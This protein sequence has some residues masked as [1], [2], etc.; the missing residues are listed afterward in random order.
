MNISDF[1]K[2][3]PYGALVENVGHVHS[4]FLKDIARVGYPQYQ[5]MLSLF[6]ATPERYFKELQKTE[7]DVN[8]TSEQIK[9]LQMF[10]IYT[11]TKEGRTLLQAA[12]S[13]F[14]YGDFSWDE[15]GKRFLINKQEQDGKLYVDGFVN[16]NNYSNVTKFCLLMCNVKEDDIPEENPKFKN[17]K[18]R[19]FYEKFMKIKEKHKSSSKAV[20]PKFEIQN[21]IAKI[22]T[23]H[24]SL[25]YTNIYDLTINQLYSTFWELFRQREL[26]IAEMNYSVWG[27]K[28]DRK[29]WLELM[30]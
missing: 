22:C 10:D 25:N 27:G 13:L 17:E 15:I 24:N 18:D 28:Y 1:D 4:P 7:G 3:S 19:K 5:Q 16:R 26:A 6:L 9:Q 11:N 30:K 14:I 12:L 21:M 2:N 8:I 23:Y 20:D 29:Q